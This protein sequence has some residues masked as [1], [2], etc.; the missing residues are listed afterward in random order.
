MGHDPMTTEPARTPRRLA[1]AAGGAAAIAI[2]CV[3]FNYVEYGRL[4]VW[5]VV[6][7][8][9]SSR[10]MF[11]VL[12]YLGT[13]VVSAAALVVALFS[14]VTAVRWVTLILVF[15]FLGLE[16]TCRRVTGDNIGFSQ[17]HTFFAE[18]SFAGEFVSSYGISVVKAVLLAG[19]ASA[20]IFAL[21]RFIR[22]R[23]HVAWTGLVPVSAVLIYAVLWKTVAFT[24][25]YPS[26]LRVP[27]LAAYVSMN[28]LYVG[29]RRPVEMTARGTPRPRVLMLIVDESV[30]GDYLGINGYPK[31]TTPWLASASDQ[32]LNFG[33]ACSATNISSGTNIILQSGLRTAECPDRAQLALKLPNIFQYAK[34]A[35]YRT[36]FLDGQSAPGELSNFMTERDEEH[37]DVF[38]RVTADEREQ[39][40]RHRRDELLA[41]KIQE[42]IAAGDPVYLYV[43][44]Y[45]AH[46][47]YEN[48][49]PPD[50]RRFEPTM[51]PQKPID[52]SRPE[53]VANSYAN[54]IAWNVD[55]FFELLVPSLDLG[56]T[57]VLYTSDHGQSFKERRGISTHAD[58]MDPPPTQ[59]NAPLLAWGELLEQRFPEGVAGSR[60]RLDHF[61]LF[62][63]QLI[64]MGY[65]ESEVVSRHG[66]PLWGPPREDRIFLSGD[67]FG[68]G[69]V[70]IN[71]F[72]AEEEP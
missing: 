62:P 21:V 40:E 29:P 13:Y 63:T 36:C 15:L 42:I 19:L 57:V 37:I 10:G 28:S 5:T 30:R 45:G 20:A 59:A 60:D 24:D 53:E 58:R 43:N 2:A 50:Q 3:V 70:R 51:H 46:F 31:D 23:F 69:I 66:A 14:R 55:R 17:V 26:A 34:A 68:R 32:Y 27:V 61:Q 48:T 25:V 49:Y 9:H 64:L 11:E 47:H 18:F 7:S 38:Y 72:D 8:L 33:V 39:G 54:S 22:L 12:V 71:D 6:E 1:Q 16:L 41:E 4:A 65:P 56:E 35:G 52:A 67:L 44:K